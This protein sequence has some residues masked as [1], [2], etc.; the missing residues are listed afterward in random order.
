M[1][2]EE[3]EKWERWGGGGGG[4][5]GGRGWSVIELRTRDKERLYI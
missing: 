2:S 1:Q 5:G 3:V 4:G